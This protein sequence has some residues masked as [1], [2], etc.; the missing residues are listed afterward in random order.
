MTK[1]GKK[2]GISRQRYAGRPNYLKTVSIIALACILVWGFFLFLGQLGPKKVRR[3]SVVNSNDST[4]ATELPGYQT[5]SVEEMKA[6]SAQL[7]TEAQQLAEAGDF[8]AASLKY[9]RAFTLQQSIN[10]NYPLSPQK[11]A[12][13]LIRLKLESTNAAAEPLFRNGLDLEQQAGSLAEA[14]DVNAALETLD[15]AI[16]VQQQ[17]ND[18][19]D[20]A[21]QA[22][23]LRVRKLQAKQAELESSELYAEIEEAVERATRLQEDEDWEVAGELFQQAARLQEQLNADF[24]NSPHVSLVRLNEFLRQGQISQSALLALEIQETVSRL[25]Q[26]IRARE[27]G[28]AT[29][30]IDELDQMLQAFEEAFPLSSRLDETLKAQLKYLYLKR[31]DLATIQDQVYASLLPVPGLEGSYLFR[32][33]VPQSLYVLLVGEN[34]SRKP[35]ASNPVDSVSWFEA[36]AFC[37]QLSQILGKAVRLPTEE[38]F[39]KALGAFDP[40]DASRLAWSVVDTGGLAQP[41]GQKEPFVSGYFDLLG[42]L[43]EW[44]ESTEFPESKTAYHI[45]GHVQDDLETLISVPMR[46]MQKVDRS[47]LIGFRFVVLD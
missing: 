22:S 8:S 11:N 46:K 7:E 29:R 33:E 31:N 3:P 15:K 14:G 6:I 35:A 4:E 1:S 23:A 2:K 30:L 26:L 21:R 39:R 12:S 28:K 41:T 10:Q 27:T 20:D 13:R 9:E 5:M 43:S 40:S 34:P 42:N 44:L 32:T 19:Y 25:E 17:L 16:A 47:R 18:E 45:G 36:E 38:E 37:R 24:P